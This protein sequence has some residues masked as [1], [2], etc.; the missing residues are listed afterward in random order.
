MYSVKT[1]E[2]RDAVKVNWPQSENSTFANDVHSKL[3]GTQHKQ[4]LRVTSGNQ[5]QQLLKSKEYANSS[6]CIA[7]G[8]H[9]MG[10]QQFLTGGVMLDTCL[11]NKV[12]DFCPKR[13][14]LTVQSGMLWGD[15]VQEL[16]LL[17]DK[18]QCRWS[19]IQKPTGA[20]DISVGGSLASN[21]H[22]RI[23]GR[24]PFIADVECFTAITA[25]GLRI[26]VSRD[27][28]AELFSL[29]AGGY[30][31]FCFVENITIRLMH[32]RNLRREVQLVNSEVLLETI[33]T[34]QRKG[35]LYGDFQFCIDSNADTFLTNGILSTYHPLPDDR[36][37][38]DGNV[39]L[40]EHNWR[41]LLRLAHVDKE[42]AFS[43]YSKHYKKTNGQIYNS[44]SFQL[45]LYV[46]DYHDS[47]NEHCSGGASGGAS[48]MITELYVPKHKLHAFLLA[49]KSALREEQADIIYGTVRM[50]EKDNESFLAWAKENFACV[51]FNLHINHDQIS[52]LRAKQSF[53]TLIEIAISMSGSFYL[54]YHRYAT[55]KQLLH[56]YPQ[57]KEFIARKK[58]YDPE[59]R[60][61]SNWF[62]QTLLCLETEE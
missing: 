31:M 40:S 43:E 56:A 9:S 15:L 7:G 20:D 45:S 13:G 54:T 5:V 48:E 2:T 30:G 24:K 50:I 26:N 16:R 38:T 58:R 60:F 23:L 19:I 61:R 49:A 10:G 41:E 22:G 18:H 8:R 6:F 53:R 42:K 4:I 62:N 39:Q 33:E 21:I 59:G 14:L 44:E 12:V 1:V 17:N 29:A 57:L 25:D 28:N 52:I 27:E 32:S 34:E 51:I 35:A 3:N 11:M 36:K 46:P 55:R 47:L 37:C